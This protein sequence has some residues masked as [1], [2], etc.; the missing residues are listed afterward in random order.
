MGVNKVLVTGGAG[1]IG[2]SLV[3][4]LLQLENQVIVFDN[5]SRDGR[6][7]ISNWATNPNFK[8]VEADMLNKFAIT[9]AVATCNV[10]FHFAA[11]PSV[12]IGSVNSEIDY[13]QNLLTTY[14]LLE[15]IKTVRAGC[16]KII[17]T[18]SS[19]VYG[20][21]DV[22][23]TPEVYSPLKPISLYG[24]TKLACES[25]ISGYCHMFDLSGV[26]IRLAN[27]IGPRINHGVIYDF[28]TKLTGNSNCLGILGDGKQNKSF[29]Y[30]GDCI[31]ALMK[32]AEIE[33]TFEIFNV[34]S[35]D[36]INVADIA[37]IIIEELSLDNVRINFAG[38]TEGRG[39]KGDVKEM[40]LDC[41]RLNAFGW[42]AEYDSREAVFLTVREI[43]SSLSSKSAKA[44]KKQTNEKN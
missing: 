28:V 35:K 3:D 34:G 25:L 8:L 14:N 22:I 9:K 23:P 5:F 2:S 37:E 29:L 11:S 40:L 36:T 33:G 43:V 20:E 30:I 31:N 26:T 21:P 12:Q 32:V 39:W 16:K 38:G 24:A 1:F 19:S 6:H 15:A 10:V 42:N 13:E 27:V 18:S 44:P 7:H 17:F 4:K 41:S